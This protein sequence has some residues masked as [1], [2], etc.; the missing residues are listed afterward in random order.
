[1]SRDE[2]GKNVIFIAEGEFCGRSISQ[3]VRYV[4]ARYKQEIDLFAYKVYVS[5][6][7]RFIS[8]NTAANP[9]AKKPVAAGERFFER[10][11]KMRK[12][13]EP[14]K[15]AEEIISNLTEKTGLVVI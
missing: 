14:Q 9:Y 13:P 10:W 12:P 7:L 6:T 8:L 15:S 11:E 2:I 3:F 5:D 4:S 1:M